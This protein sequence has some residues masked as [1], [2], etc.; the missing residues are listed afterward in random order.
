MD[1]AVR[2]SQLLWRWWT[3]SK[4]LPHHASND[5]TL[6]LWPRN[7]DHVTKH[8]YIGLMRGH[9]QWV[10]KR[11]SRQW[12]VWRIAVL[13]KL[14]QAQTTEMKDMSHA[15]MDCNEGA[16]V[17][18]GQY[19]LSVIVETLR[20]FTLQRSQERSLSE[21]SCTFQ[22]ESENTELFISVH[23]FK[24]TVLFFF[25]SLACECSR[26]CGVE[27][28]TVCCEFFFYAAHGTLKERS[29]NQRACIL[30]TNTHIF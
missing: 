2:T 9:K 4:H 30:Y 6:A 21:N 13:S 26:C 8:H 10:L 17:P 28:F 20:L 18:L 22:R 24:V 25:Y 15:L 19:G 12:Q 14:I 16:K 27:L 1:G 5:S 3:Q 11:C 7:N 29:D 23:I